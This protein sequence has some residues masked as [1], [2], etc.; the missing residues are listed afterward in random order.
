MLAALL[1]FV[2]L[3]VVVRVTDAGVVALWWALTGWLLA[4]LVAV[5]LRYRSGVWLRSGATA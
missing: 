3:A 2:P 1:T 5:A 4:R